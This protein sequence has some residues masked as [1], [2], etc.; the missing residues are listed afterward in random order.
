M[1]I[2]EEDEEG[3]ID[4][5]NVDFSSSDSEIDYE[6]AY[7][8]TVPDPDSLPSTAFSHLLEPEPSA[9]GSST[10]LNT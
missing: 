10:K 2:S 1:N 7:L 5:L 6:L 8:P 4:I 3:E 9:D